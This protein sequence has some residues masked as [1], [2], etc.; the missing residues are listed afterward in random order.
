MFEPTKQLENAQS[1]ISLLDLVPL[2]RSGEVAFARVSDS[3]GSGPLGE[4]YRDL[5]HG[6]N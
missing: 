1:H 6:I 3:E 5:N 4:R 2:R